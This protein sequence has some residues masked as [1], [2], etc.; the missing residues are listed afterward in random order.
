MTNTPPPVKQKAS[1]INFTIEGGH[2]L[3]GSVTTSTSKNGAVALLCAS[4]LNKDKTI[5]K[6]VPRI[7]EVYRTIEVLQSI[8]VSVQWKENDVEIKPPA[9]L[10]LTTLDKIAAID[11]L[12]LKY[13]D[14][15]LTLLP[16]Y[17]RKLPQT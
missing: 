17:I 15:C 12:I 4:L 1:V 9:K 7:E 16:G 6:N 5:L 10:N 13:S 8:G 14:S 11:G 2:K 3:S